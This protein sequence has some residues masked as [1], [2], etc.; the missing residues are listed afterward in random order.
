M[1]SVEENH[2]MVSKTARFFS[3][4]NPR[5]ARHLLV[6]VH[7]YAQLPEF[8]IRKFA[9]LEERGVYIV[10]PEGLHRFYCQGTSGRVGASWMTKEARTLDINDNFLYLEQLIECIKSEHEFVSSS[11]LGFSQ[12]GATVLRWLVNS[13]IN[14]NK[15]VI[16]G[17]N[18]PV[19]LQDVIIQIQS[20]EKFCVI[21]KKDEFFPPLLLEETMKVYESYGFQFLDFEGGHQIEPSVLDVILKYD[22]V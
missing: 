2:L 21:G 10:A 20:D 11:I 5:T 8:F 4:G 15:C 22:K 19:D 6:V 9:F 12:G 18:F 14:W 16:W 17:C 13:S 3:L 7:G 1:A